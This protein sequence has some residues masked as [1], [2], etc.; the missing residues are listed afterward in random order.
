MIVN[1]HHGRINTLEGLSVA[2]TSKAGKERSVE[3]MEIY[4]GQGR[5]PPGDNV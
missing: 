3:C 2:E 4:I 1:N 5:T